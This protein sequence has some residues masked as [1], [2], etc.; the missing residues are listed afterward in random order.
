MDLSGTNT[1]GVRS[2]VLS[3]NRVFF[4][5]LLLML[6]G[7]MLTSLYS[8][9]LF[10][11]TIEIFSVL[12]AGAIFI[13]VWNTRQYLENNYLLILGIAY[14]FIGGFDFI[15]TLAYAGM[16]IFTGY[17]ADLP[18][19]LWIIARYMEAIT[20]VAAPLMFG[21][22]VR[23]YRV[24][25]SYAAV[26]VVLVTAVFVPGLFPACYV[27]GS[28]L[29]LFKVVS[30]Y[31]ISLLLAS[32]IVLLWY[33][34]DRFE[35]D[36]F[37]LVVASII[38]TICAEL[39]FTFYVSVYGIS[40]VVGHLFK[41]VSFALIYRALVVSAFRRPY[42]TVF[43]ELRQ[44]KE[45]VKIER[46]RLQQ[47]LDLAPVMFIVIDRNGD[48]QL[49]NRKGAEILGYPAEEIIGKNWYAT[50]LP[51]PVR[52]EVSNRFRHMFAGNVR[53]GDETGENLVLTKEG[54]FRRMLWHNTVIRNADGMITGTLSSGEDVTE[55]HEAERDL[56]LKNAAIESTQSG[57]ALLSMDGT[58]RYA[59]AALVRMLG[60]EDATG[61]VGRS[62]SDVCDGGNLGKDLI[63][64]FVHTEAWF[65]EQHAKTVDGHTI[66]LLLSAKVIS[67]DH[68]E[69]L[70]IVCSFMDVTDMQRYRTAL[71]EA[72]KKLNILSSLTRHD[73]LN[74]VQV[75]LSY[76]ELLE[77]TTPDDAQGR[78]YIRKLSDASR[79]IYR[80]I[81]FTRDYQ[82]LGIEAPRWQM[83][84]AVCKEGADAIEGSAIQVSCTT[85]SLEVYADAMLV[86]VF[87][88]LFDNAQRHG[89]TVTEIQISFTKESDGS[90]TLFV[91]DN[92]VGVPEGQKE[93]IFERGIGSNTGLGLFIIRE[94]LGIT[95]CSIAET[96]TEGEGACFSIHI[97]AGGWRYGYA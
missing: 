26:S 22:T 78:E 65:G 63:Y 52:D 64:E 66:D 94:V 47:Y 23:P 62:I 21:R 32:A 50:F 96:G 53:P 42:E 82:D 3:E 38:C 16:S 80:Q 81:S 51:S 75:L 91:T 61:L 27:E 25:G 57:I 56:H 68:D 11:V 15:H 86:K 6:I 87:Y 41:L 9:L 60:Y 58:I 54:E 39:A 74:Q 92:G 72:N 19:Q 13:I 69:P 93:Q 45:M 73:I 31:V 59:N 95:G 89:A 4:A 48:V 90:G 1:S 71:K 88:N 5:V 10:H 43:R 34:R 97:P 20:L 70:N 12:I 2:R 55:I 33:H 24:L 46:D 29:T 8:F 76:S 44:S 84:E 77:E 7:V 14:L 79:R 35:D 40:N 85:E 30:E 67:S 49:I 83:V 17:D 36:I 28:G 37:W 18:T